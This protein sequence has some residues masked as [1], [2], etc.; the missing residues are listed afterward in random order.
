MGRSIISGKDWFKAE[1]DVG[2]EIASALEFIDLS[3]RYGMEEL[4]WI[5]M[6]VIRG[7]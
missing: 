6:V 5:R 3:M 2:W 4:W 1:L 7:W